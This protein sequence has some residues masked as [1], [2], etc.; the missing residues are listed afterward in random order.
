MTLPTARTAVPIETMR[1]F[2]GD[3]NLDI[4]R[5]FPPFV[6]LMSQLQKQWKHFERI[7]RTQRLLPTVAEDR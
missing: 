1:S 6:D 3:P 7:P 5:G 2:A 4:L